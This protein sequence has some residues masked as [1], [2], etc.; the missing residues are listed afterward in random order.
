MALSI[1]TLA[2]LTAAGAALTYHRAHARE[3]A[4]MAAYPPEGRFVMVDGVRLHAV[5]RGSG[6]DLVLI[7]G[8][9]GSVRDFTFDLIPRLADRY[10]VIAIDRPGLGWSDPA[11]NSE[12]LAEQARLMRTAAA[13]LGAP[14]PIVLGQSYG[15]SV[16]LAW[17]LQAPDDTAALVL[18]ATPSHPWESG[19][20][21][22][23][24]TT[25]HPLGAQVVVPLL[26]AFVPREKV[27]REVESVFAPQAAPEGYA[28]Y[29]G[30]GMTLRRSSLRANA[31]QR[32]AL[33]AEITD[34]VPRYASLTLP[35]ELVH[36]TADTTVGLSIHSE[37][38]AANMPNAVLTRLPGIGHMPHHSAPADVIDAI[39]RAAARA[40]LR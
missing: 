37:K 36:G 14:R 2:A 18:L 25:S 7:H 4:A 22:F 10:R 40:G 9:S 28:E 30:P 21:T 17:A 24:K 13:Q 31:R 1:A 8:S 11:P 20:S 39:D 16:A 15:G 19:L 6:P 38:L 33:L 27:M 35:A 26:T 29:F 32:A 23:Y 12:T 3:Q 34:M 5:V